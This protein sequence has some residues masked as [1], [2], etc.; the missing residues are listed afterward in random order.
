MSEATRPENFD[1]MLKA[2]QPTKSTMARGSSSPWGPA[3]AAAKL[4]TAAATATNTLANKE[5]QQ[6]Q[7]LPRP[8]DVVA[9]VASSSSSLKQPTIP[10]LAAAATQQQPLAEPKRQQAL[11]ILPT[12][13]APKAAAGVVQGGLAPQFV[14][15]LDA[16]TFGSDNS[17]ERVTAVVSDVH[18]DAAGYVDL[19]GSGKI[20]TSGEE[21]DHDDEEDSP[22]KAK[23]KDSLLFHLEEDATLR[24]W[25]KTA[26]VDVQQ[27]L[28][29]AE[30]RAEQVNP[31]P[32]PPHFCHG[33]I[34]YPSPPSHL[35]LALLLNS[36]R[37]IRAVPNTSRP[38]TPTP[39]ASSR[40]STTCWGRRPQPRGIVGAPP[41][42]TANPPCVPHFP[43]R[44]RW[45]M[46]SRPWQGRSPPP[47]TAAVEEVSPG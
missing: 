46:R 5:Q 4:K 9:T 19:G 37:W 6:Q 28:E 31:P 23:E 25:M 22:D 8:A 10:P 20:L 45:R 30:R 35:A 11:D 16:T 13:L 47:S 38:P 2:G 12:T 33:T 27:E 21:E 14:P 3:L 43:C 44:R 15:F 24:E 18:S 7:Q 26:Q 17:S 41:R 32:P 40:T 36:W 1:L 29:L 42:R 34:Y 39:S